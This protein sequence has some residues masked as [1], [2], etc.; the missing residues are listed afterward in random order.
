MTGDEFR[1]PHGTSESSVDESH[2]P[3]VALDSREDS[4]GSESRQ[5]SPVGRRIVLG[6][7]GLGAV[8]VL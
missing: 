1:A 5:G 4:G 7:L 3:A 2:G 8:G 6:M